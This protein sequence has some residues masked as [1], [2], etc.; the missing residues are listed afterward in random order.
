MRA[1]RRLK[2]DYPNGPFM[3]V[4]QR[5]GPLTRS[6]VNKL[7]TRAGNEAELPFPAHPHM[8]RQACGYY[9]A[10][11]GIDTLTIQELFAT[12]P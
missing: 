4:T 7:V 10:N 2:R 6:T 5:G 1:L 8:L 9:M 12:D 11:K 3:F